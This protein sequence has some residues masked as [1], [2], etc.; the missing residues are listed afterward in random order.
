MSQAMK[1]LIT[2][3]GSSYA[4][5]AIK[6]LQRAGL[7]GEAE[8]VVLS[9]SNAWELPEIA[10]SV[11][12]QP[13]KPTPA[14]VVA[15]QKHLAEV[16][17]RAQSL[18]NAAAERL[19]KIFPDW[20]VSAEACLGKPAWEVIKKS[21]EWQAELVVVGPQGH[22]AL[23]RLFLGSVSQKVLTEAHCSVRIARRRTNDDNAPLRV[24]IAV[25]GSTNSE[26]AI[27]A[28]AKRLWAE[29]TEIHLVAVDDP[30]SRPEIGY[31]TWNLTE[32]KPESNEESR[33]WISQVIEKTHSY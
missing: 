4:D 6:E 19:R 26:A 16:I 30:F 20:V 22:T 7:P 2:Y 8:A 11:S 25:D 33:S 15:I 5:D 28:V 32:D 14:F 31:L 29:G 17:E 3:D 21:D 12:S 27:E 1:I 23:G 18:S 9:V 10:D 24:L 13:D